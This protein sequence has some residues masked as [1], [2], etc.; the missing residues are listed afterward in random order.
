VV[1]RSK[2]PKEVQST[3]RAGLGDAIKRFVHL[4]WRY[5]QGLDKTGDNARE[6]DLLQQALNV[7]PMELQVSCMPDSA[8]R[9]LDGD[10]AISFFEAAATSSCCRIP[11]Q[12]TSRSSRR[13]KRAGGS[14]ELL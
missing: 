1:S 11:R 14:H 13:Q 2:Q 5:S 7:I 9:D 6:R 4:S 8:P 10:G 3:L 12:D